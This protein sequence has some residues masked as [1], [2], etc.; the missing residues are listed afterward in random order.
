LTH[1]RVNELGDIQT[2]PAVHGGLTDFGAEVIRC[3]NRLGIVVDVAH[4]TYDLVKRAV[5][6]TTRPIVLSHTNLH[7][8]PGTYARQITAAHAK[9][10]AETGGVI[11]V[12]PPAHEFPTMGAMAAGMARM[13]DAVGIDHVGLGTDLRGLGAATV[14]PDYDRLP[15]LAEALLQ[16][17]FSPTD[18]GKILGGNYAR[19]FTSCVA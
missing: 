16:A 8:W 5:S 10:I 19:V 7:A 6:V 17:G 14:F 2:T 18:A 15:A 3:C 12:W 13:V 1:Y 4:G 9:L 11:G